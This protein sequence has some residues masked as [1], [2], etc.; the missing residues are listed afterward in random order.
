MDWGFF[1]VLTVIFHVCIFSPSVSLSLSA[2]LSLSLSLTHT[3]TH[4][5][6]PSLPRQAWGSPRLMLQC[7]RLDMHGRRI[8]AGYGF[9]HLPTT[10]GLHRLEVRV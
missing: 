3:Y 2:S 5:F 10:T 4:A 9:I 1:T 6:I 7:Y 8:L